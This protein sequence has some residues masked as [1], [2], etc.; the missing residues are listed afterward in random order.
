MLSLVP[1]PEKS[2]TAHFRLEIENIRN[3]SLEFTKCLEG[4]KQRKH[5]VLKGLSLPENP[6]V[7][8]QFTAFCPDFH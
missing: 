1:D 2:L 8:F 7:S 3:S 5:G 4:S 6:A